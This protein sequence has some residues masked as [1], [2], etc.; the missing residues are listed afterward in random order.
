VA[1]RLAPEEP[2][3]ISVP[4]GCPLLVVEGVGVGRREIAG[5]VDALYWVQSDQDEAHRRDL[6]RV[7]TPGGPPMVANLEAWMSE[8][9]PFC[10]AERTWE[11][12][13][14]IVCGTPELVIGGAGIG[15]DPATDIVVGTNRR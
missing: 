14:R 1:L 9:V 4:A 3:A 6:A 7:G 5:L 10:A 11:R 15:Y 12:A 13:D 8:E 2:E